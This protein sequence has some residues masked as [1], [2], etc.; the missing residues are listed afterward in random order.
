MEK[1]AASLS[2]NP[3]GT[4]LATW[5]SP[6]VILAAGVPL[7]CSTRACVSYHRLNA[8]SPPPGAGSLELVKMASRKQHKPK[9]A[10]TMKTSTDPHTLSSLAVSLGLSIEST[11]PAPGVNPAESKE[12]KPWPH[13]AYDVTVKRNGKPVW[14]GPYKLGVG[15]VKGMPSKRFTLAD[16]ERLDPIGYASRAAYDEAAQARVAANL[17]KVQG[18]KPQLD[19]VLSSLLMDGSAYFDACTFEEWC[20]EYGY[21]S[22]SRK[23]ESIWKA[24]DQTGRTLSRAFTDQELGDLR[25]AASNH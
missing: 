5:K 22:D 20:N 17:A 19:N 25:E 1:P 10:N 11:E 6:G 4:F 3:Q 18:V 8:A 13:I 2:G 12:S 24:C 15:H 23:A 21:D 9:K 14:S 16:Q 7:K